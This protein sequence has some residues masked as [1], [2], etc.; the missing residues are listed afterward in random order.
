MI[1]AMNEQECWAAVMGRDAAADG[2]FY[3]AVRTTGVYCRPSCA[4]RAARRENVEFHPT[5]E[6]AE[7]AGFRA[8]KRCK[9]NAAGLA[10]QHAAAVE[11]ACRMIDQAESVPALDELATAAGMSRFH[12]HRVFKASTGLTPKA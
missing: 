5:C 6:A 4:S 9:P 1:I 8:C 2:T 7:R 10:E 3:Y 11:R 12:F